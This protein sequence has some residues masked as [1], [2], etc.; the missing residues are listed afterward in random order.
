MKY[1]NFEIYCETEEDQRL[2]R[3]PIGCHVGCKAEV[4]E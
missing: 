2:N 3:K 4:N 1:I